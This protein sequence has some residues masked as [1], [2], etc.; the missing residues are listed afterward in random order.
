VQNMTNV[1]VVTTKKGSHCGFYQGIFKTNSWASKL[2]A[3]FF[4]L[5][6]EKPSSM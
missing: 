6:A 5:E 3:D 1:A 2:A 4:L